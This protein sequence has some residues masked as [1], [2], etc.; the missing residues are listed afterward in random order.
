METDD[1]Y[2]MIEALLAASSQAAAP[3]GSGPA[4]PQGIEQLV[5][6]A[7]P[8]ATAVEIPAAKS[9]TQSDGPGIAETIAGTLLGGLPLFSL[10][11]GLFSGGGDSE[12]DVPPL[13]KYQLPPSV[14]E[15]L[16]YSATSGF[17]SLDY[18]QSGLPRSPAAAS[19][20]VTVQVNAMDSRSFLDHSD[21]IADAVRQAVLN[22]S[23]LRD[24]LK[25]L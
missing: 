14:N 9:S 21:E 12:D 2:R 25:E 4:A 10:F 17:M 20:Q 11:K 5:R 3:A 1:L 13:V 7:V 23:S 22:S 15:S 8:A 24:V 18:A 6:A 16:G 19:P